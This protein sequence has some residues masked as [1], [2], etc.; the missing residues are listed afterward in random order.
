MFDVCTLGGIAV[1]LCQLTS[2]SFL[3]IECE[4]RQILAG[5]QIDIGDK[6]ASYTSFL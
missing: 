5:Q 6:R 4:N 2:K 3:A 1:R